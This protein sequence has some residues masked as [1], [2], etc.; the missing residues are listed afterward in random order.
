MSL[1]IPM[2]KSPIDSALENAVA[3]ASSAQRVLWE[4]YSAVQQ[5]V[6]LADASAEARKVIKTHL[7][8]LHYKL[9]AIENSLKNASTKLK[10]A[11]S[12]NPNIEV[13]FK[14]IV[15]TKNLQVDLAGMKEAYERVYRA[16]K[17]T[18]SLSLVSW[19]VNR[20]FAKTYKVL[21]QSLEYIRRVQTHL[22][23]LHHYSSAEYLSYQ[24]VQLSSI[25]ALNT[26]AI[27]LEAEDWEFM[28]DCEYNQPIPP[29]T[30][31]MLRALE[32]HKQCS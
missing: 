31:A 4:T 15:L 16:L 18:K 6:T 21:D 29:P 25:A 26:Q 3:L 19:G 2:E 20:Q 10:T 17:D 27:H 11:K 1:A 30:P 7:L 13:E 5:Y 14:L 12:I 9:K 28:L 22:S 23:R 8:T 32:H 24:S